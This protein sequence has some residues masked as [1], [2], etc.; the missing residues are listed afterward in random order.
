M[1]PL[2]P[3][4]IQSTGEG[5]L[6]GRFC[7]HTRRSGYTI[8]ELLVA[9][10]VLS[11]VLVAVVMSM[12][13]I[14]RAWGSTRSAVQEQVEGRRAL[15][16]VTYYLQRATLNT[17]WQAD[18]ALTPSARGPLAV[19]PT[20]DLH[21]VSGPSSTLLSGL[22]SVVGH[23]VFFQGHFGFAGT[24]RATA[25]A[26]D[27]VIYNTLPHTLN[28]WGYYVEFGRDPRPLPAFLSASREG[29]PAPQPQYRFRLMEYRQPAH[30]VNLFFTAPQSP[31]P[32]LAMINSQEALYQWFRLPISRSRP[33]GSI[34]DLRATVAAENILAL[35]VVPFQPDITILRDAAASSTIPY[36]LA[37][38][39]HYD[40]R[41]YQWDP[42]SALG[43]ATRNQLPAAVE[44]IIVALSED[45]WE[46]LSMAESINQGESLV[47]YLSGNFNFAA[48]LPLDLN[49]LGEELTRR[50]LG[51][52]IFSRVITMDGLTG[53]P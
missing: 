17:R 42:G 15:E 14:Q 36:A 52:K 11:I 46:N 32:D 38:D 35:F 20:S 25:T 7:V 40:S 29:R 23:A 9:M 48:N 1:L 45:S 33:G 26:P 41:R 49:R 50:R 53:G 24:S 10:T 22:R 30:E 4:P 44:V 19:L 37:P 28:G 12:E 8:I 5:Q 27:M 13:T 51:Y 16:T 2:L 39:F 3:V 31:L 34:Q 6:P 47:Q 43:L 18:D 21:F